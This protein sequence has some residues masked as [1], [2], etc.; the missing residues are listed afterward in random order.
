MGRCLHVSVT[1]FQDKFTS[2]RQVN[3]PS[4]WGK[5]QICCTDMYL[6]RF[7]PNFVVLC[8]FL[9]ISRLCDGAKY[10]KPLLRAALFTL[11]ELATKILRLATIFLQLVAKRWPEDFFNFEP[12]L[13]WQYRPDPYNPQ[14]LIHVSWNLAWISHNYF[15]SFSPLSN[16]WINRWLM[17]SSDTTSPKPGSCFDWL[18]VQTFA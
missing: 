10:Q 9:W 12:W 17:S 15:E 8:V 16:V 14:N 11:Y 1:K 4:S 5:F 7:L 13:S 3:S 18:S 2:L 6:I